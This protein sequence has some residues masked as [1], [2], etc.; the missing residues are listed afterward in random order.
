MIVERQSEQLWCNSSQSTVQ[1]KID[2]SGSAVL[3]RSH[4]T[5]TVEVHLLKHTIIEE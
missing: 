1:N 5:P 2:Q 3:V 4:V